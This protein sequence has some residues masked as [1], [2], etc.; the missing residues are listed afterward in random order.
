MFDRALEQIQAQGKTA[1][2][3]GGSTLYLA[4]ALDNLEFAP[5]DPQLRSELEMES[6][7]VGALTMHQRLAQLDPIA[8]QK[9]PAA[10]KR[11]VIRALEVV[12]I[13]G[14]SFASSLPTPSFRR[15]TIQLAIDVP[16]ELLIQRIEKRV[17]LMWEQGL[18]AEVEGL[19]QQHGKLSAT[20]AVA[21]GYQQAIAQLH[22]ELTQAQAIAETIFLTQRYAKKQRTWF[23]RDQR[24]N[25]LNP[26]KSLLEKALELIRL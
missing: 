20:A 18:L 17:N 14:K 7:R 8:A 21:I 22:G 19:L 23:N 9:I 12:T 25:W 11:R 5:T 10:N 24:I 16:R 6:E 1:I 2:V 3:V 13:S 4:S 15:P 26:Q